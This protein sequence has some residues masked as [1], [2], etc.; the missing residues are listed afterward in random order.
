MKKA[1]YGEKARK[2]LAKGITELADAVRVTLG[3]E[4]RN[5]VFRSKFIEPTG[6]LIEGPPESTRDGVTV[7]RE[8]D[9]DSEEKRLGSDLLKMA[10]QKTNYEVGDG[11]ST[12]ILLAEAFIQEGFKEVEKGASPVTLANQMKLKSEEVCSNLRKQAKNISTLEQ[13]SQVGTIA[14]R[15]PEIGLLAAKMIKSVGSEGSIDI[16]ENISSAE[17]TTE[18]VGGIKIDNGWVAPQFST[19]L[20]KLLAIHENAH[21]LVSDLRISTIDDLLPLFKKL[22][23]AKIKDLVIF[24]DQIGY[25]VISILVHNHINHIFKILVVRLPGPIERIDEFQD[26]ATYAG[27]TF[28]SEVTGLNLSQAGVEHLGTADRIV[29]SKTETL[30]IGGGGDPKKIKE[31]VAG[32]KTEHDLTKDPKERSRFTRR[33]GALSGGVAIIRVGGGSIFE[34]AEKKYMV[35]DAVCAIKSGVKDGVIDGGGVPLL[36]E[37]DKLGTKTPID[38]I[39]KKVL[40]VPFRQIIINGGEDPDKIKQL[41]KN[42]GYDISAKKFG[43]MFKMGIIDPVNV[44]ITALKNAVS[45][46]SSLLITE[47]AISDI[48][49]Q[50]AQHT[51]SK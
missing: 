1:I 7:A 48:K 44:T 29:A 39:F 18:V 20:R 24:T 10:S 43:D 33:I 13:M 46:A 34:Q 22:E 9:T 31:K 25:G 23:E 16:Q 26:L 51:K 35:E 14:S 17:T 41:I 36:R 47:C 27:A 42:G 6:R 3:G 40:P 4:G 8:F 50:N 49:E 2:I 38:R 32:L 11:T 15:S 12:A 21:I 37:A 5:V 19:E 28:I 45:V 30:V